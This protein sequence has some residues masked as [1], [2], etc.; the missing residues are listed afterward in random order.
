MTDT[1][2]VS[3]KIDIGAIIKGT[4]ASVG[5]NFAPF[6]LTSLILGG[7]P[8]GAMTIW[9]LSANQGA[10]TSFDPETLVWAPVFGL[11]MILT[12]TVLQGVLIHASVQDRE[13]RP[14]LIGESLS[15]GLRAFLPLLGLGLLAIIAYGIG[16]VLLVIPGIML[17]CAWCVAAPALLV[18]E[19][20]V[21]GAFKRSG[22][23]TRGNRWRIFGLGIVVI[24]IFVLMSIVLGLVSGIV[25]VVATAVESTIVVQ[26]VAVASN[27]ISQTVTTMLGVAGIAVLYVELRRVREGGGSEKLAEVFA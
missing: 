25:G 5:R 9:Q 21:I 15:V 3:G 20:G 8:A 10:T 1:A 23:L 13:G 7:G 17:L 26:A 16:F 6:F 11:L 12:G 18:E 14:V 19:T 24:V 2:A 4:F 27:I 22:A